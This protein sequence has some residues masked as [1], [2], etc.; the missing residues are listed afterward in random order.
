MIKVGVSSSQAFLQDRNFDK[1]LSMP[2]KN[3]R[4]ANNFYLFANKNFQIT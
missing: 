3:V 2:T 4:F 1:R